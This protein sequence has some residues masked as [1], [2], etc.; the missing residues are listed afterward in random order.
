M[1]EAWFLELP[2]F[3]GSGPLRDGAP[4]SCLQKESRYP[5]TPPGISGKRVVA[6]LSASGI[7]ASHPL[8]SATVVPSIVMPPEGRLME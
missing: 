8:V 5:T 6:A 7:L 4:W 3:G 2:I 1:L